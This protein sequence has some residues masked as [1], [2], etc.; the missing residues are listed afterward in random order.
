M[1]LGKFHALIGKLAIEYSEGNINAQIQSVIQQLDSLAANPSNADIAKAFKTQIEALRTVLSLSSLNKPYPTLAALLDSINAQQFVGDNLFQNIE[2][3]IAKNGMT[4]QLAATA[5]R[6]VLAKVTSFYQDINALDKSFNKLEVEY[7]E[8]DSGEG[9]IGIS[10]PEPEGKRLLSDLAAT[11]KAWDKALRP[12]VEIADPK[13]EPIEVRTISSSDWQFYLNA[14]V[15]VLVTLSLAIQQLNLLLQKMVATKKLI[16]QLLGLGASETSTAPLLADTENLLKNGTRDLAEKI[17]DETEIKDKGRANELKIEIA[18]SLRF[19]AAEMVKG[20]TIE[21]RYT[22]PEIEES[23]DSDTDGERSK[24]I[25]QLK[26][27]AAQIERNMDIVKLDSDVQALLN[28]PPPDEEH[29][30][31]IND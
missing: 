22:P 19:I 16:N 25:E 15:P 14:S 21:I 27:F 5:L 17:V 3:A 1:H 11:A 10:I 31:Q 29:T 2:D 20:V 23:D 30:E 6:E 12:F 4:P 18:W 26:E 7:T 8:L 13:N 28:L 24:R 9:E